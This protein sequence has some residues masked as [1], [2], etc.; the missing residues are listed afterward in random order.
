MWKGRNTESD[1]V[2]AGYDP[3]ALDDGEL[4]V[5]GLQRIGNLFWGQGDVSAADDV[6]AL[7][8]GADHRSG[9]EPDRRRN[10]LG[11]VRRVHTG[12]IAGAIELS[13][14]GARRVR[15]A[16]VGHR[17]GGLNGGLDARIAGRGAEVAAIARRGASAE[18]STDRVP[19]FPAGFGETWR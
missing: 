17:V 18:T 7:V 1:A 16:A 15:A 6:L 3:A 10:R 8:R 14:Q 5:W 11:S 13:D 4:L 2:L 19:R 9:P 12:D